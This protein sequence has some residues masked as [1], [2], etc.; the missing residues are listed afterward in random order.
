[1]LSEATGKK[2]FKII[3]GARFL[4]ANKATWTQRTNARDSDGYSTDSNNPN[5]RRWCALGALEKVANP[6]GY[7][8]GLA[9]E[10]AWQLSG[11]IGLAAINDHDGREA[12]LTLFDDWLDANRAQRACG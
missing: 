11:N 1:M 2:I 10:A 4:V 6:S 7:E 12:V 3:E 8:A 9:S 5:A